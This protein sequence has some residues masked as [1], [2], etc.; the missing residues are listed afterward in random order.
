M[1]LTIIP[2][3]NPPPP[4]GAPDP[5]GQVQLMVYVDSDPNPD[6]CGK[7]KGMKAVLKEHGTIWDILCEKSPKGKPVGT[8]ECCRKSQA[9]KDAGA[10]VTAAEV[11]G[12]EAEEDAVETLESVLTD[13]PPLSDWCCMSHVLSC[14]SDFQNEKPLIQKYVEG[15]G[16]ICV[17][18]PKFHCELNPI[19][20]VWGYA[21]YCK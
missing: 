8:C 18:L 2:L 16:H 13:L 4:P 15:Q 21:K 12:Q 11:A 1:H 10:R 20:M 6:L 7:A 9:A 3:D 5:C 19:E 14:Q 17:F